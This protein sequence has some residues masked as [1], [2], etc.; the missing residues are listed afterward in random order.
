MEGFVQVM[1]LFMQT[2][3]CSQ[4]D[5]TMVNA[6]LKMVTSACDFMKIE[7]HYLSLGDQRVCAQRCE[8]GHL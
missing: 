5:V 2:V 1:T 4:A 6:V 8:Q 7:A 3:P